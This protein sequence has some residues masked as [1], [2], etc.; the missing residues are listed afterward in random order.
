[1]ERVS[2]QSLVLSISWPRQ[3][4]GDLPS[5]QM[6]YKPIMERRLLAVYFLIE[7]RQSS[8]FV[9][10]FVLDRAQNTIVVY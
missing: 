5:P 3:A 6:Q 8:L 10:V 4:E 9:L 7:E 1:M 2:G